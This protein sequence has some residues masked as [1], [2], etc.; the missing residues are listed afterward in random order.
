MNGLQLGAFKWKMSKKMP[1]NL[2]G[3][4]DEVQRHTIA[5]TL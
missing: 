5:E 4:M 3:V 2:S 1:K